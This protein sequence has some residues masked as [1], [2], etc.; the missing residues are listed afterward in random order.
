MK[1]E[2]SFE[3]QLR[4]ALQHGAQRK[5]FKRNHKDYAST[6]HGNSQIERLKHEVA[7][8]QREEYK[9]GKPAYVALK[10]ELLEFIEKAIPE[11]AKKGKRSPYVLLWRPRACMFLNT[12][13]KFRFVDELFKHGMHLDVVDYLIEDVLGWANDVKCFH[14]FRRNEMDGYQSVVF[15]LIIETIVESHTDTKHE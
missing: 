8:M 2:R 15:S 7:E 9:P 13:Q 11:L 4:E 10:K 1:N 12:K 14:S 6:R 3:S 5:K